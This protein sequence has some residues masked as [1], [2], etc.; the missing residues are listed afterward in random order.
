MGARQRRR[1]HLLQETR[2]A[3]NRN[4]TLDVIEDGHGNYWFKCEAEDCDL[5][6]TRPGRAQCI[7][8]CKFPE[9]QAWQLDEAA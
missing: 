4:H 1:P 8:H 7:G 5:H 3:L 9:P 2:I 6:V